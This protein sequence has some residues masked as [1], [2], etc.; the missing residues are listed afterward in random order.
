MSVE[1]YL[2]NIKEPEIKPGPFSVR[3]KY[4]LKNYLYEK[5][6]KREIYLTVTSRMGIVLLIAVSFMVYNPQLASSLHENLLA[7]TGI[8][9][10][11]QE[12]ERQQLI[13]ERRQSEIELPEDGRYFG[14]RHNVST[15]SSSDSNPFQIMELSDLPEDIP[16]I[17]RKVRDNNNRVIYIINEI[18]DIR[19]NRGSLY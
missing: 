10:Q 17:I 12:E 18:D 4:N 2:K 3:L 8:I 5:R 1:K 19:N 14:M 7:R 13:V 6:R 9:N 11:S 15:G 16:F